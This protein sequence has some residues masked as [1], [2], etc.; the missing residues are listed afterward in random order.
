VHYWDSKNNKL[1]SLVKLGVGALTGK[2]PDMGVEG[3]LNV[4]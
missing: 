2:Q 3:K 4:N 1:V